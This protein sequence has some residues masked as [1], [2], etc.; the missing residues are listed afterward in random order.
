MGPEI[1][2]NEEGQLNQESGGVI[3]AS[4]GQGLV[5]ASTESVFPSGLCQD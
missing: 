3:F 1:R 4:G 2:A 5:L